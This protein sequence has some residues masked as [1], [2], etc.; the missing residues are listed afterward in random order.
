MQ[1][2]ALLREPPSRDSGSVVGEPP[3]WLKYNCGLSP[4]VQFPN[5]CTS[6]GFGYKQWKH[7]WLVYSEKKFIGTVSDSSQDQ[8]RQR[9][10]SG[11]NQGRRCKAKASHRMILLC[12]PPE[13]LSLPLEPSLVMA[14]CMALGS[15]CY[16]K[17]SLSGPVPLCHSTE[18]QRPRLPYLMDCAAREQ[19]TE[20]PSHPLSFCSERWALLSSYL[21]V[22]QKR[23]FKCCAAKVS[24]SHSLWPAG[25]VQGQDHI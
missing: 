25:W 17:H 4:A 21:E 19:E 2:I 20:Y 15:Q 13:P 3:G 8:R 12:A 9:P 10:G 18:I 6:Q 16:S 14:P 1:V 5:W 22:P 24:E 23:I 11:R 7:L